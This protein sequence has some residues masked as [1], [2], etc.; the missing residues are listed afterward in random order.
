M[1][2]QAFLFC[3]ITFG[4]TM[5]VGFIVALLIKLIGAFLQRGSKK[6]ANNS[7]SKG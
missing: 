1:L 5:V 7:P 4:L 6:A 2:G 3:L